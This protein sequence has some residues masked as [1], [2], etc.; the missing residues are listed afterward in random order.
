MILAIDVTDG[1]RII[2]KRGARQSVPTTG[3]FWRA[4]Q[5]D[6][7]RGLEPALPPGMTTQ[8]PRLLRIPDGIEWETGLYAHQGAAVAAFLGAGSRGI[9]AIATGGGKTQTSLIAAVSEQDRHSGPMLVMVYR[10]DRAAAAP[11]DR[12]RPSFRR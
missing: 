7:M 1:L 3:D 2:R 4:W 9:L 6:H 11:V 5:A 8:P 12:G 10:A